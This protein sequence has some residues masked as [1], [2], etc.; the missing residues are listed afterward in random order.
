MKKLLLIITLFS[1]AF[2]N[3]QNLF[4]DDFSFYSAPTNFTGSGT[5]SN[6]TSTGFP[7]TGGCTGVNCVLSKIIA[8]PVSYL[9]YGTSL[10]SIELK[11]ESDGVG[12][13]FPEITTQDV[14]IGMVV[15]IQSATTTPQDHFRVY[16]NAN[17]TQTAFRMFIKQNNSS[18]FVVGVAKAGNGNPIAYTTQTYSYNTNHLIILNFKQLPGTTDDS[19][20]VYVDPVYASGQPTTPSAFTSALFSSSF[21]DQSGLIKMMAF[22]QN[23]GSN[24]PTGRT[25]LISVAKTWADLTFQPLAVQEFSSSNFTIVSNEVKSGLLSIKSNITLENV[26]LNIYDI[27]GRILENKTIS[28]NDFVNNIQINSITNSGVYIVELVSDKGKFSQKIV[29][30]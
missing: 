27:Q 20:A 16:N 14:Y 9:D 21:T 5:W 3:A 28:L 24:L 17:F 2:L 1:V 22:R 30:N 18:D 11:N 13:F 29:V 25:G 10:N 26:N 15:N 8:S 7:G 4:Q 12:T 6:S 19:I 23:A